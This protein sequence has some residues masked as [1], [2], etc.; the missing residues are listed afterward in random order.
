[1]VRPDGATYTKPDRSPDMR[2][3]SEDSY[4]NSGRKLKMMSVGATVPRDRRRCDYAAAGRVVRPC[5][6]ECHPSGRHRKLW[7][8]GRKSREPRSMSA[9][10]PTSGRGLG[11]A[12]SGDRQPGENV[13]SNAH[14]DCSRRQL[15]DRENAATSV[16]CK[17]DPLHAR[18][19]RQA[20][21]LDAA[22]PLGRA[23]RA[24]TGACSLSACSII[25]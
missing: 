17:A 8:C 14:R 9:R 25:H 10:R 13:E 4:D 3:R 20:G 21:D 15:H 23:G 18:N 7:G 2:P 6:A 1:M 12:G 22:G 5:E 19:R 11:G 16:R 24:C